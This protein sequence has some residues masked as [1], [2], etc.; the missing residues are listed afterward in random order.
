MTLGVGIDVGYG[1][2][3]ALSSAGACAVFPSAVGVAD[4]QVFR[5]QVN[6]RA[7][8]RTHEPRVCLDG[9]SYLVGESAR[10]HARTVVQPRDRAWLDSLPY[11]ILWHAA[12]E[13]VVQPEATVSIVT[14]LPVSFYHDR[15]RLQLV[16]RQVLAERHISAR[17]V[18][19]VPQP[20][21]SF[22]DA[23]LDPQGA[24]VDESRILAHV[25]L[26][27]VGYFTTDLVEVQEL[28]YVQKGS[29]SIEVGVATMI[30]TLRALLT[31]Q[32]GRVLSPHDAEQ[33]LRT[34]RL[35]LTGREHDLHDLCALAVR[36]VALAIVT[37][38]RQLWGAGEQLDQLLLTGGGGPL[39]EPLARETFSALAVA[40]TPHLANARGYVRYA[41]YGG[42]QP[43]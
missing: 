25:G 32:Y 5:L 4:P 19:I 15:E 16:M 9:V 14:G 28:E 13:R 27:D 20:F 26:I 6:G 41:L 17:A 30:D 36:D 3:K 42:R 31:E 11:R 10:R 1:H 7:T 39:I 21:G 29:G 35:R 23:V 38:A 24:I 18:N 22:F 12:L 37:Y 40:P 33:V 34:Q 2:T 43:R 8:P